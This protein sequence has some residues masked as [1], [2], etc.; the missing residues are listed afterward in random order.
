METKKGLPRI[1][2]N[3][4]SVENDEKVIWLT[5]RMHD[6]AIFVSML[7][8]ILQMHVCSKCELQKNRNSKICKPSIQRKFYLMQNAEHFT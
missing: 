8:Y 1:E 7:H 2:Q 3:N 5:I 6:I 4:D